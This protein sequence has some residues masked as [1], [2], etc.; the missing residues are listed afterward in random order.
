MIQPENHCNICDAS[1]DR[2]VYVS[3]ANRS[4]TTMGTVYEG[5]TEVFFCKHCGHL[6]TTELPNLYEYYDSEYEINIQSEE[7]DQL[8]KIVDGKHVYRAEHQAATFLNKISLPQ[9]A[10]VLDYGCAKSA[11]LRKV[12]RQ[13]MDIVPYQ[14]DVTDKYI[15][16]W[17]KFSQP[18]QW[19]THTVKAEWKGSMDAV[20]SF[21]AFEHATQ[22]KAALRSI[23]DLLKP[24]GKL[25]FIVPNTYTNAA[26]FVVADHINHFSELSLRRLLSETGF[27]AIE[28]DADSHESAFIVV[29]EKPLRAVA[30][31][32]ADV[33][34]IAFL[35]Q[36]VNEISSYWQ[37]IAGR[38]QEFETHLLSDEKC[39][40][41]GAGFYGNFIVSSLRHPERIVCFIDQNEHLQGTSLHGKPVVSPDRLPDDIVVLYI[42]LNPLNARKIIGSISVLN[43]RSLNCFFL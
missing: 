38:I 1:F 31:Y 6:Q 16:F 8:Y 12:M 7:D 15:P 37:N 10:H 14:F 26:D 33:Q 27:E 11:T 30:K 9:S 23:C 4:I 32:Q 29:A 34:Q 19:A 42:G 39:A 36:R 3:P 22:L 13:R 25:Y 28:V 21:Y 18:Q 2:P 24:Q 17:K 20:V 43:R 40:I 41:Y 35:G 5:K